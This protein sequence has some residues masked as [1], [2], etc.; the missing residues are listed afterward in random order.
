M[1]ESGKSQYFAMLLEGNTYKLGS[2]SYKKGVAQRVPKDVYDYLKRHHFRIFRLWEGAQEIV[3]PTPVS[4][5]V[6]LPVEEIKTTTPAVKPERVESEEIELTEDEKKILE[7]RTA[8]HKEIARAEAEG[9]VTTPASMPA[10]E[11]E[12]A[13]TAPV[14]RKTRKK[15]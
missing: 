13:P 14:K 5:P 11:A 9:E 8:R 15:S 1:S 10:E 3:A 6:Q 2:I 4:T 7:T 12:T